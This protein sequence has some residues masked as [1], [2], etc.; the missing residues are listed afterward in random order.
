MSI[1]KVAALGNPL[2]RQRSSE[3]SVDVIQTRDFQ[4]L[5]DDMVETMREYDGVGIAAPQVHVNLR[6]FTMEVDSNPRYPGAPAYPLTI[7]INPI[8]VITDDGTI[9]GWEGC[10]SIPGLRGKVSRA[11][12]LT[13]AGLNRHGEKTELALEGFPAR[14]VQHETDHLNGNVYLDRMIDL[15][16][17]SFQQEYD[18]FHSPAQ[19][20]KS[21]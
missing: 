2:L 20:Q 11:K 1:L 16:S 10:L 15:T 7:V 12:S 5:I 3:V 21:E 17:L 13:V 14:V 8:V 6:V 4:K 19:P 18:R 9:D